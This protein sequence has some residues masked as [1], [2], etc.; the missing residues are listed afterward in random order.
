MKFLWY[1]TYPITNI[2]CAI[3]EILI[4]MRRP[5]LKMLHII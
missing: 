4:Y 2:I 1:I 5:L 3:H